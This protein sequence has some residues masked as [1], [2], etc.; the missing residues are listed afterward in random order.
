MT[1]PWD[2]DFSGPSFDVDGLLAP[3]GPLRAS[4]TDV[5]PVLFRFLPLEAPRQ[6]RTPQA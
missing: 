5:E 2:S 4:E 6:G 3:F 1:D